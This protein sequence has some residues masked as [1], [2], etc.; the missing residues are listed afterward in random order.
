MGFR[1]ERLSQDPYCCKYKDQRNN[2]SIEITEDKVHDSK[3][4]KKM[5]NQVLDN[6]DD[7]NKIKIKSVLADGAHM[8]Q[9]GISNILKTRGSFRE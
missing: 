1:K 3:M 2:R 4:L 9:T 6:S 7:E 5:I 8:I